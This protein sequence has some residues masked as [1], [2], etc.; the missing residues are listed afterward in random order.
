MDGDSDS[1]IS[2]VGGDSYA[3]EMGGYSNI[4][5]VG[6]DS[7]TSEMGGVSDKCNF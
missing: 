2:V 1:D 7:D 5:G 3:S 4:G 6:W